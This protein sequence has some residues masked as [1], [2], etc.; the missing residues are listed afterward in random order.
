M[1]HLAPRS[2]LLSLMF[3]GAI[4]QTLAESLANDFILSDMLSPILTLWTLF[5]RKDLN[6]VGVGVDGQAGP[7]MGAWV[8][9]GGGVV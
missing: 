4:F 2:V 1:C 3:T 6:H 7:C 8:F 9:G 5:D